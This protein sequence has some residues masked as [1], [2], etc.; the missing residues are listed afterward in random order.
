[1]SGLIF[2]FEIGWLHFDNSENNESHSPGMGHGLHYKAPGI[3]CSLYV[4][5]RGRTGIPNDVRDDVI[6]KEFESAT[7]EIATAR[8]NFSAWPDQA[9]RQDCLERFYRIGVAGQEVS[10]LLLT[11]SRGPFVKA[12][13]TWFREPFIDNAAKNFVDTLLASTRS[14]GPLPTVETH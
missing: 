13:M 10:L 2:P 3:I 7:S 5:D 14:L 8:P 9:T 12:R 11:T 1:V 6:R 4:Y